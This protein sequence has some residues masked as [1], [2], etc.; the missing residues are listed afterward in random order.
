MKNGQT[1]LGIRVLFSS[2][3]T[4]SR[5]PGS[6]D[7]IQA[8]IYTD[9]QSGALVYASGDVGFEWGL[10]DY[11]DWGAQSAIQTFLTNVLAAFTSRLGLK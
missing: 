2:Y 6:V 7:S 3:Y 1:P 4:P 11:A 5:A 9:Q 8:T 10:S